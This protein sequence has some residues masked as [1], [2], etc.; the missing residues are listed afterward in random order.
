MDIKQA[1]RELPVN[2]LSTPALMAAIWEKVPD[3]E[4]E[5]IATALRQVAKE[6]QAEAAELRRYVRMRNQTRREA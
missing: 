5:D 6:S 3:A 4:P 1:I 2:E